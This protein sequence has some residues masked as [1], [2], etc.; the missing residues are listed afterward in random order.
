MRGGGGRRPSSVEIT[1]DASQDQCCDAELFSE[2]EEGSL[3]DK[4]RFFKKVLLVVI[5]PDICLKVFFLF[6]YSQKMFS[7]G[8]LFS[9]LS[10]LEL[11]SLL[12]LAP[13]V[14]AEGLKC[15]SAVVPRI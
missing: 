6:L 9:I 5:S 15:P 7:Q 2:N 11:A 1:P 10:L 14:A 8:R 13:V 12:F 3:R 4:R